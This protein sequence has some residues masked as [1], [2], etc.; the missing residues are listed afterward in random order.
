MV[1]VSDFGV[2][3]DGMLFD[4]I[5]LDVLCLVIGVICC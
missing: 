1:D 4:V 2:W 3:W 5:L